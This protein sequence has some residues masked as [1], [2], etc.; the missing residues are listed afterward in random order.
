MFISRY[1]K[2]HHISR[3]ALIAGGIGAAVVFFVV[4]AFIRLLVGPVSLGPLGSAL[5]NALAE[6]LPGVT[7]R[8]DQAAIEWS[9]DQG[10]VNLVILGA[11]VYDAENR[12]IAQAPEA[13]IGL[14]A[15]PLFLHGKAVVQ[16]I[17]LVG[18]QLTL[19]RTLSGGLRLGVEKDK[20]QHDILSRI[21]D[22]VTLRSDKK[23]SLQAFAVRHARLAFYDEPTK[24]F[25]VAPDANFRVAT[26]GA[27][28]K[29]QLD[30]DVEVSG[31]PAHVVGEFNIPQGKAP[32]AGSLSVSGL[33]LRALGADSKSFASVKDIGLVVGMSASF[34]MQGVHILSAD[35][36][37]DAKGAL[38]VP[39]LIHGPLQVRSLQFAG[40]YDGVSN[41]VLIEDGTLDAGG[42]TAHLVAQADVMH[43][44]DGAIASVAFQTTIDK[45]ALDM[46]GVLPGRATLRQIAARGSYV[47]PTRDIVLD[48]LDIS[49]PSLSVQASGLVTLVPGKAPAVAVKG[50]MAALNVRD[51]LRY[52]PLGVGEGARSWIDK[53]MPAATV[54]PVGFETHMPAGLLDENA[55]PDGAMKVT[56]PVAGAEVNYIE[57]LTHITQLKGVATL[58]GDTFSAD[59]ASGKVGPL[60]VGQGKVVIANLHIPAS[61]GDFEVKVSGAMQDVLS[62]V[63]KKPL[64]YPTRFGI[65]IAGTKGNAALDLSFHLPMRKALSVDDVAIGI[66]AAVTGFSIALGEHARLS[67]GA[68]NFEIDNAK[69]HAMGTASLADSKLQLDWLEDFRTKD[70]VTT[71]IAVKGTLDNAGREALNFRSGA[72]LRGPA[73]VN[74]TITGHRGQLLSADMTMDLTPSRLMLDLIGLDKPAGFPASARVG[75]TFGPESAIRSETMKISGPGVTATGGATFDSNGHMVQLAFPT[76]KFGAIDDFAFTLTRNAGTT[77]IVLRGRSLDGTK[78]ASRGS[79]SANGGAGSASDSSTTIDGPFKI[80]ARIDKLVLREGVAIAPF[81]LDVAGVGDRPSS[82]LL[83]GTMAKGA[84]IAGEMTGG[85]GSRKLNFSTGDLGLFAKGMFGFTS[86]RGGRIELAANLPGAAND[87]GPKEGPDFQGKLILR[88]FKIVNQPFLARLFSAGSLDGLLN[89]MQGQGIAVDKLEVPFTSKNGVIDVHG[90]RATGPAIGLTADGWIDRPKNAI[91]MKGTLAPLFGLNSFLGNVP[92]VG[93]VLVGKQGEGVFGMTYSVKGNADQP[94]VS[95]NPLSVLAPGILRRIFEGNMPKAAQAPSNAA[96]QSQPAPAAPPPAPA[97]EPKPQ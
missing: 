97:P 32:V 85:E 43:D 51:M 73:L 22:A 88:D 57:G 39:G 86:L 14:A 89:L 21:A 9:R 18:V 38:D 29:A 83:S 12:I 75:A 58:T 48:H 54:G 44:A 62:L 55:L 94:D 37:L 45:V 41:R 66:K 20:N 60:A 28:L 96:Q 31:H 19:V 50:Q 64:N 80:N 26:A 16:R 2:A 23:S 63:D 53:N 79:S 10:K 65:D 46:P 77:E 3:A 15:G 67:D 52:W 87:T 69:L 59:I 81:A 24:L 33:D 93:Q 78:L 11:K 95:V 13:D 49:G 68:V 91:A 7:V 35:F 70:P 8:Y 4:G 5:P 17:T 27:D 74:A 6:A 76:I 71:R 1:I 30:A 72:F 56:I 84:Q 82:L 34:K 40:R 90:A 61:P 42:A 47:L 25:L 92:I 36:G